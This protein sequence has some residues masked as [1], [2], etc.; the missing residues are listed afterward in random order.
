MSAYWREDTRTR[1][2]FWIAFLRLTQ[3]AD[4]HLMINLCEPGIVQSWAYRA[5]SVTIE[6]I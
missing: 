6:A 1:R 4:R 5:S 2:L 3:T